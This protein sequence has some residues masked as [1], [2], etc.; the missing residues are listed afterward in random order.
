MI[1]QED[2]VRKILDYL[3]GRIDLSAL[4]HWSENALF[5]LSESD[6]DAPNEKAILHVLGYIGA[7]DTADFPLTWEVLSEMLSSLGVRSVQVEVI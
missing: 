2:I 5:A 4:V 7:G 6:E 1:T 3:N